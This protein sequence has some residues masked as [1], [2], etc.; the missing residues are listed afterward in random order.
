M[1]GLGGVHAHASAWMPAHIQDRMNTLR[2][3]SAPHATTVGATMFKGQRPQN[4]E[5][6]S[7]QFGSG[8]GFS[9]RWAAPSFQAKAVAS[10]FG[11]E[12]ES[13]LPKPGSFG[14]GGRGSPD[15]AALGEGYQVRARAPA[16][17][18]AHTSL[19]R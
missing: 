16:H 9:F 13:K 7:T 3:G 8:G 6:A 11:N 12:P 1:C 10:Y 14:K 4:G 17:M 18:R 19:R 15:I 2:L 5:Q